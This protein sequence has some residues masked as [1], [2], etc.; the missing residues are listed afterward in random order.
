MP[1]PSGL[2]TGVKGS[3][4]QAGA[5]LGL[6]SSLVGEE[7]G[8]GHF[9]ALVSPRLSGETRGSRSTS[10]PVAASV[11]PASEALCQHEAQ[12]S[13]PAFVCA[14]VTHLYRAVTVSKTI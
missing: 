4:G 3:P 1:H 9:C 2:F 7:L 5:S 6:V 14:R 12:E 8:W 13:T 11:E 10:P